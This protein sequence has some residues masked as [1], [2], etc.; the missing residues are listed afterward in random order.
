MVQLV[1]VRAANS[2]LCQRKQL[3]AVF[4]GATAGIG[5]ATLR[6]LANAA[7]PNGKGLRVYVIGRKKET[8]EKILAD[9]SRV[10]PDGDFIFVQV[11]DLSLIE[12]V[13]KACKEITHA[14][15]AAA[16]NG[17]ATID[18]LC[19]SQGDFNFSPRKGSWMG[20]FRSGLS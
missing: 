4:A 1:D 15:K 13:D 11:K 6:A 20:S 14:V 12:E 19:M 17:K 8:T 5:E 18:L 2:T 9:C 7:G 3:T 16:G 10:C